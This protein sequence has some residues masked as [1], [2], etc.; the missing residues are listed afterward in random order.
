M[1]STNDNFSPGYFSALVAGCTAHKSYQPWINGWLKRKVWHLNEQG[2][3]GIIVS[4]GLEFVLSLWS[5]RF[6]QTTI[7]VVQHLQTVCRMSGISPSL[8]WLLRLGTQCYIVALH[9]INPT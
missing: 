4:I 3:P 2:E 6:V 7:I 1:C 5:I 9:F 8:T